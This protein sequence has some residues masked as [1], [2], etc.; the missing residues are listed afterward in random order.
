MKS[1]SIIYWANGYQKKCL[2]KKI[3]ILLET[4]HK[5]YGYYVFGRLLLK[6][7]TI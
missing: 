4:A 5:M 2:G 3:N 6:Y 7:Y 1:I